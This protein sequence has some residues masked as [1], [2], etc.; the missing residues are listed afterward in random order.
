M[1]TRSQSLEELSRWAG[2]IIGALYS[3]AALA[4]VWESVPPAAA[5]AKW[6]APFLKAQVTPCVPMHR[7]RTPPPAGVRRGSSEGREPMT[8]W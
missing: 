4:L 5:T 2:F 1:R 8:S 7:A 6:G 3:M